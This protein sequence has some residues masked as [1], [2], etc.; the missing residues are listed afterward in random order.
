MIAEDIW[1]I[2]EEEEGELLRNSNFKNFEH[3]DEIMNW[4]ANISKFF[5]QSIKANTTARKK[6]KLEGKE[7]QGRKRGRGFDEAEMQ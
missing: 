6:E 1:W 5:R 3:E 2:G 4:I 7:G